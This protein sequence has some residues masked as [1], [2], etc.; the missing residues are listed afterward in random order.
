MTQL[1]TGLSR[2]EKRAPVTPLA[3]SPQEAGRLLS[4]GLSRIY[5]L[6]RAGEL[7]S[8]EAGRA[9]RITMASIHAYVARRLAASAGKW[10]QINPRPSKARESA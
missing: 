2:H 3:V 5:K 6:L 8:F 9:R 1:S 10:H 7:Q 4:L